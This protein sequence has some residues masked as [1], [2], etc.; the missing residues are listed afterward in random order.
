MSTRRTIL[1][2]A[3]A[4]GALATFGVGYTDTARK[5]LKGQWAGEKP[6]KALTGNAPEPEFRIDAQTGEL[7]LNPDQAVSYAMCIGCTTLCGVRVRVDKKTNRILRV[8]GNPFS[9]MSTDPFLPYGTSVRDS[10]HALAHAG[11]G[12]GMTFRSTACGRG[13]AAL[14]QLDNPRRVL[15]PLKRVGPRGSGHWQT[16]PFEQLIEEVVEGGD[17]FGEGPVAGLREIRDLETPIK[18]GAP[19]LGPRA[20]GLALMNCVDDG[21]DSLVLRW[22]KQSFGSQN[23]VRHGSYCGGAYRS[24][25]GALFGD[26]KKMPHAKPDFSEAEFIIFAGTAPGNAGNPFKRVGTLI[27]KARSDGRTKYVVVDPM[28]NHSSSGPSGGRAQWLPIRPGTDGALAMGMMR[29]IFEHERFNAAYLAQ[30][31]PAAAKAA[32]EANWTNATHLVIVDETHPRAG[33]FLRGSDLD[34]ECKGEA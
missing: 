23:F 3:A 13:N 11:Q 8:A 26:F 33:R 1:K 22:L 29:W 6:A 18:Q 12:D 2:A 25:S 4:T 19:E 16:I 27:A 15:Q 10:F 34:P 7:T 20:N 30:P 5:L 17:L 21:R 9:P 24:G 32:G 14:Q 28:L 31:S